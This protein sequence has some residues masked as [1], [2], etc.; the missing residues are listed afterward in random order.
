MKNEINALREELLKSKQG[1]FAER[2]NINDAVEYMH[3]LANASENPA[4]FIT[5][6]LVVYN[7]TLNVIE[8][9]LTAIVEAEGK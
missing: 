8:K 6:A 3:Q 2:E 1:L 4:A 7:T 9:R 5:G